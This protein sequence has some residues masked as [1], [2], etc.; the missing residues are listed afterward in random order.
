MFN[1][2]KNLKIP[3]HI[4]KEWTFENYLMERNIILDTIQESDWEKKLDLEDKYP[5]TSYQYDMAK[6]QY[7]IS[8]RLYHLRKYESI[9][10]EKVISND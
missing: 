6:T 10:E 8:K 3:S 4:E 9:R 7:L 5:I 2:T 1:I